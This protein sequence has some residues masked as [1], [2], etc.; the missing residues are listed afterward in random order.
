MLALQNVPYCLKTIKIITKENQ[1]TYDICLYLIYKITSV[2]DI[3]YY[4]KKV[5]EV[6]IKFRCASSVRSS[7][8]GV[9]K[10]FMK[11]ARLIS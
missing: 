4:E 10:I 6:K 11:S 3:M 8:I 9:D 5:S 7:A 1:L 2:R